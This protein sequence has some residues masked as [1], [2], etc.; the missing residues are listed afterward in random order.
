MNLGPD[1]KV[2]MTIGAVVV[3]SGAVFWF[4]WNAQGTL[5]SIDAQLKTT[6]YRLDAVETKLNERMTSFEVVMQDRFTK[7]AA[8]EW[9][10][11]FQILHPQLK[12]PDPRNPMELLS[13]A[14]RRPLERENSSLDWR[15]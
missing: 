6:N 8:A 14:G 1:A 5:A 11:R 13:D 4:G 10:L 2:R 7:T 15:P 12:I 3:V 9:A